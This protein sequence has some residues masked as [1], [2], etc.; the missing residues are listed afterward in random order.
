VGSRIR[1]GRQSGRVFCCMKFFASGTRWG[2]LNA[3]R[4]RLWCLLLENGIIVNCASVLSYSVFF[5]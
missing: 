3:L 2:I 5:L 4:P 1:E